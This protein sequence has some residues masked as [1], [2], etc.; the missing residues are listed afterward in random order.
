MRTNV[1]APQVGYRETLS[2]VVTVDYSHKMQAGGSGQYA[3]VKIEF[4]PLPPGSG[5][6]FV[7][8]IK[9]GSVPKEFIPA[10]EDGIKTQKE[11]GLMAGFPVIDFRARLV[12]GNFHEVDSS[13]LTFEIAARAAF[14]ELA[15]H[16]AV[17]LLEPIMKVEVVTPEDFT[18]GVIGDFLGRRAWI[19]GQDTRGNSQV[20]NAMVPLANMFSYGVDLHAMTDG[21]ATYLMEFDHYA[22]VPPHLIGG[23]DDPRFPGAAAMRVA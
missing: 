4:E 1:D 11:S 8:D 21:R 17:K 15:N 20:I 18:G 7:D 5:F 2:K 22:Q 6:Q 12:D 3:R 23:D 19:K 14:R 10:V 16:D 13:A 9:D